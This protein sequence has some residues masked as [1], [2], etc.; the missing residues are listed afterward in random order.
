MSGSV[1]GAALLMPLLMATNGM[2]AEKNAP[3]WKGFMV[4][5]RVLLGETYFP[6]SD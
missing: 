2:G 1:C 5:R 3:A 4:V 6:D